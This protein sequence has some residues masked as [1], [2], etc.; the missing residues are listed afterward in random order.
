MGNNT[1]QSDFNA[2]HYQQNSGLSIKEVE[3]IKNVFDSLDP[4][5]GLIQTG[6][7]RKLYRDSYDAPQLNTKIGDRETLTFDQ[8]FEL[9]K[10]DMLEKKRQFPGVDFDDGINENVQCFFCHPQRSQS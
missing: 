7:L 10:T 4:K 1:S 9:M 8:F 5:N 6:T 2:H 3:G